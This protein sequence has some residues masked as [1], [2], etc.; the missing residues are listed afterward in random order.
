MSNIVYENFGFSMPFLQGY[1][2]LKIPIIKPDG[3]PE[4]PELFPM[5]RLDSLRKSVGARQFSAQMMLE[6]VAPERARLDPGD[7]IFYQDTFNP[8][9]AKIG[10]NLITGAS[11]YWDP[12]LG[13][14][15][16]DAS[17]CVLI[18]RDDNTRRIFIYDVIYL[19]VPENTKFPMAHQ[20]EMILDFMARH[21]MR[22]IAIEVN[23]IGNALPEILRQVA[24]SRN[25]AITIERIKNT[26]NK[27]SR[28]LDTIEPILTT[29]RLYAHSRIQQTPIIS[30]MLAWTPS[31][32]TT[33]DD[34]IDALAGAICAPITPIR[35]L[36]AVARPITANTNFTI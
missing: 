13:G 18:Y 35:P 4:W 3:T 21:N 29:G 6:F 1:R 32:G 36:G 5:S 34:G 22:R 11:V 24:M 12:S 9:N 20:C 19:I 30:E 14:T 27:E 16:S 33:H 26:K 2:E 10:D 8:R 25:F 28:I 7:L 17:V 23:G 31:G 15:K